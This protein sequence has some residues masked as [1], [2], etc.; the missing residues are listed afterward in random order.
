MNKSCLAIA[1]GLAIGVCASADAATV[2]LLNIDPPGAGL[3]DTT[4]AAPQGNNPGTTVGDQRRI[5]YEFAADLWGAVLESEVDIKVYASFQPLTCTAGSGVLGAAGTNWIVFNF[6]GADPNV[7]YHSALGDAIAGEDLVPDPSDPGDI[8]SFFNA[9]L[10][11]PDCLAGS[12]WYYGLDGNTPAGQINFLNVVMHEIGHGL[13]FSGFVNKTSGALLA[14]LPDV[15]T[16]VA[17]DNQADLRFTD[18]AMTNA[19][20]AAA[21]RTPGRS[22]WDGANVNAQAPLILDDL[23]LLRA[24]GT[25]TAGFNFGLASFGPQVTSDNFSGSLSLV[26][27]GAGADPNDAC[28]ALPAGSLTGR[29]ALANRGGCGFELKAVNAGNAGATGLIIGNAVTSPSP[30]TPPN[31]ADDPTLSAS[32]P[33]LSVNLADN[34]ALQAALPGVDVSLGV[35]PGRLAGLDIDGRT[36]LY[37]PTT[38]ATG[39]TFSHFDTALSPNALMEPFITPTLRSEINIDLTPALLEDIGWNLN[40]GNATIGNCTTN[41][42]VVQDGGLIPGANVQAWSNLCLRTSGSKGQYQSCMDGYKTRALAAG[43][44]V[45][46]QGGKVMSCAAKILK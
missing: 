20:R 21:M 46:N 10:G 43:V 30:G 27:D 37:A 36:Q 4:P 16:R 5:A 15:Y 26:N 3:N 29:I 40:E 33:T 28:E 23:V 34:Q 1:L 35:V 11:Q 13:G 42:D 18:P 7:L 45:G 9:N 38:V 22:V 19:L 6:P 14:N 2:Q 17:Y 44:L 8:V 41:V 32:I 24:S 31:M 25:L 39:S 12:G